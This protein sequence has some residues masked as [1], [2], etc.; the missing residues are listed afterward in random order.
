[1]KPTEKAANE[2]T[3]LARLCIWIVFYVTEF[4]HCLLYPFPSNP[5]WIAVPERL[6]SKGHTW[7]A[8]YGHEL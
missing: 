4:A 1:M 5:L 8:P 2:K 3:E 7:I 6:S